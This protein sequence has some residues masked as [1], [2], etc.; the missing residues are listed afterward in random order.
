MNNIP[1]STV[2]P[3]NASRPTKTRAINT[4]DWP[5]S[6]FFEILE[7]SFFIFAI[8][9]GVGVGSGGAAAGKGATDDI[10]S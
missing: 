2:K 6:L 10:Y 5:F 8:N 4:I 9:Y 1:I 7:N 3:I